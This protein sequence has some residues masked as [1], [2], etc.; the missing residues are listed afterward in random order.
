MPKF[1]TKKNERPVYIYRD[2]FGKKVVEL[3]PGENGVT[4]TLISILHGEDDAVHNAN[5]RDSY[6]GLL[7]YERI[8]TDGEEG[9]NDRQVD[10]SDSSSNPENVFINALEAAERA[11]SFNAIWE[12]L[13]DGQRGLIMKKL[14][15]R[16]NVDIAKDEG[17]TEAAIRNRLC[18]IQKKFIGIMK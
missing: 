8:N 12:L 1:R 10:L 17:V 11:G 6:H 9:S 4:N 3:H 5:K 18:K 2:A 16:S 13:T 15:R 14:F 7:H